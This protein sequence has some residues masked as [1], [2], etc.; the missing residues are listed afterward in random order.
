VP[1]ARLPGRVRRR[2]LLA[3][4]LV[5]ALVPASA[6]AAVT[7]KPQTSTATFDGLPAGVPVTAE[8]VRNGLVIG[9]APGL[10][11]GTIFDVNA[12]PSACWAGFTPQILPGDVIRAGGQSMTV[13]DVT[14]GAPAAPVPGGN[15]V[16]SGSVPAGGTLA[17]TLP[18]QPAVA[19]IINGT[20]PFTATFATIVPSS[21]AQAAFTGG[22]G[23]TTIVTSTA[24]SA[25]PAGGCAAPFSPDAV[26]A[27]DGGH[28]IGGAPVINAANA[29][30]PLILSGPTGQLDGTTIIASLSGVS[31]SSTVSGHTWSATFQPDQLALLPDGQIAAGVGA[32]G[33]TL[34]L[35]K[36]TT[37]PA[38]PTSSPPP[39]RYLNAPT[40]SLSSE[41]GARIRFTIDGSTP[42]AASPTYT[43][44]IRV[45]SSSTIR[46]FATDAVGNAGPVAALAYELGPGAG[47][48]GTTPGGSNN[49]NNTGTKP[50]TGKPATARITV[51]KVS[52]RLSL[53]KLR[54]QGL[55]VGVQL[56]QATG[57]VR[58]MVYRST[59][60]RGK[61]VYRLVA[62]V[63]RSP[64]A[65]RYRAR[66]DARSLG[67][68]SVGLYRL[69]V[70]PGI[71]R[72]TLDSG[73]AR[74]IFLRVVR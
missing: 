58:F 35:L 28:I 49:S 24:G 21:S 33:A 26:T 47:S 55:G 48:A 15:V 62:S 74:T 34:G 53:A 63:V 61:R 17:V 42:T 4:G 36:D 45:G 66:L 38:Q 59:R 29:G 20:N 52:K 67:L 65:P 60:R 41:P 68:V 6:H 27:V 64:S 56:S 30:Q 18:D 51:L 72:T 7:T 54:K 11:L 8:L 22:D 46:A 43:A 23:G 25:G 2:R 32:S 16:V 39:G 9:T 37:A 14:V 40:V 31:S 50:G 12:A 1:G 13:Q 44:P 73:A 70:V 19:P 3:A 71:T 10:P 69:K 5:A 57:A